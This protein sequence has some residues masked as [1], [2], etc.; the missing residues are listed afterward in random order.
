MFPVQDSVAVAKDTIAKSSIPVAQT[1]APEA[2]PVEG[3]TAAEKVLKSL[4]DNI[5]QAVLPF[6]KLAGAWSKWESQVIQRSVKWN[7][8]QAREAICSSR[9]SQLDLL[10]MWPSLFWCTQTKIQE[11][12][13][14]ALGFQITSR[15]VLYEPQ[16]SSSKSLSASWG[17]AY[18]W[19]TAFLLNYPVRSIKKLTHVWL[20]STQLS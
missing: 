4:Y 19:E 13:W 6:R 5:F 1:T 9:A 11:L 17:M 14:L 12:N 20:V 2:L 15:Q 8:R 18:R 10:Q 3:A 7:V 16:F